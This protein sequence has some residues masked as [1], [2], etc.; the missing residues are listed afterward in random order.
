MAS[1]PAARSDDPDD[2][3]ER[4]DDLQ[5]IGRVGEPVE[6]RAISLAKSTRSIGMGKHDAY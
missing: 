4:E 6:H 3:G 5:Q 1:P 2:G